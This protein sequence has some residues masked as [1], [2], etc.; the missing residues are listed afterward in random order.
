MSCLTLYSE[1]IETLN[2]TVLLEDFF[3]FVKFFKTFLIFMEK[4]KNNVFTI[5]GLLFLTGK[6]T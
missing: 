3:I 5:Y 6:Q 4:I 2:P 1:L